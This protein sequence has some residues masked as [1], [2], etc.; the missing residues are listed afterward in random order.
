MKTTVEVR[1]LLDGEWI[2]ETFLVD[3][4]ALGHLMTLA[5]ETASPDRL[6]KMINGAL[7]SPPLPICAPVGA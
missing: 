6:W 1:R 4:D 7:G 2:T 3:P 5:Y